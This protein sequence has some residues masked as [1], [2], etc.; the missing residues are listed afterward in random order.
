MLERPK[1]VK[2][3]QRS[4]K[5]GHKVIKSELDHKRGKGQKFEKAKKCRKSR[6]ML[7]KPDV[8][9]GQK[10]LERPKNEKECQRS[11]NWVTK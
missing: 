11:P 1:S 2:E 7:K 9:K 8:S 5:I 4:L 6:K 10:M 3:G